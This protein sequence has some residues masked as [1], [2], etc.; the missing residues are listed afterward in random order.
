[1]VLTLPSGGYSAQVS[2]LAASSGVALAEV[3]DLDMNPT[4]TLTNI[5]ARC[6]VGTSTNTAISG[7]VIGGSQS[8]RLLLRG[9][10]P[11]LAGFGLSGTVAQPS[12]ALLDS[13]GTLI[14]SDT[15]WGNTLVLGTSTV[16][17]SC[18]LAT[19]SDMTAAGAF[20]LTPGS[21]DS[22]MVVTLPPGSYTV[23][24]SG[25][26]SSTGTGLAEIYKF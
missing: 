8:A 26:G 16:A 11:A 10:G 24:L 7:T 1:M 6:F 20:A 13:G 2:G 21:L 25:A 22:A 9:I 17:A 5:S 14:A 18:R 4:Q 15:G 3:Y 12:I 19:G 23:E